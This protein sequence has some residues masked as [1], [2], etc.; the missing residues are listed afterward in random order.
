M[1]VSPTITEQY[2]KP[3]QTI[4]VNKGTVKSKHYHS[5]I[6]IIKTKI[7]KYQWSSA[8]HTVRFP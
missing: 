7:S 8:I 2:T 3:L 4:F 6:P 1:Q 5:A